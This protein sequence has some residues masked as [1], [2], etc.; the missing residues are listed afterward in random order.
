MPYGRAPVPRRTRCPR[1]CIRSSA[2]RT[3]ALFLYMHVF[4]VTGYWGSW[5]WFYADVGLERG[6]LQILSSSADFCHRH[7]AR[8]WTRN[9]LFL[10]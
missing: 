6:T 10:L 8:D 4:K 2:P 5:V 7:H 1:D 3:S 9:C